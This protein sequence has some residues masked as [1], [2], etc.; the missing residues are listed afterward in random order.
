MPQPK[1]NT[2]P[3]ELTRRHA[4]QHPIVLEA[5]EKLKARLHAEIMAQYGSV[6]AFADEHDISE[7][8]VRWWL[9]YTGPTLES[10][11]LMAHCLK[12]PLSN[13][14]RSI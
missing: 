2:N 5:K 1:P 10:V 11:I 3:P 4:A 13:I 12:I 6:R 8:R 7:T 14:F 9:R